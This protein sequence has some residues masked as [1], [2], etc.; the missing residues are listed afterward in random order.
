MNK[1]I[2]K[3]NQVSIIITKLI[4]PSRILITITDE[5]LD[6]LF[7]NKQTVANQLTWSGQRDWSSVIP[8]CYIV[9]LKERNVATL[10][11]HKCSCIFCLNK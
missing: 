2:I 1:Q 5:C 3:I 11:L 9:C 4:T 10:V 7:I 8:R 6:L